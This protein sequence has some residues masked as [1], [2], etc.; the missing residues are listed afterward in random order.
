MQL[1]KKNS[2]IIL[3]VIIFIW[4]FTGIL[5]ELIQMGSIP[6]VIN[7]MI[8][9]FLSLV[10]FEFF[11][12]RKKNLSFKNKLYFFGTGILIS[13]HWVLFF[14][15]INIYNVSLAVTCLSTTAFFTSF[16][17][18]IIKKNK[19]KIH[20]IL[21][22]FFVIIGIIIIF[23]SPENVNLEYR[24]K[25]IILSVFSAMFASI[26]TSL[27]SIFIQKGHSSFQ[28]TKYEMIGG[29]IFT[30]IYWLVKKAKSLFEVTEN[31]NIEKETLELYLIIKNQINTDLIPKG[32]D[33]IY[34]LILSII[35]TSIAY[36]I[37]VE[38]MK[39]IKPFTMNISV[40]M[41]PI[42]AMILAIII[43]KEQEIMS[44][45]FYLGALIIII[46][47]YLNTIFKRN[48]NK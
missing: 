42:Y 6:L 12:F 34:I 18:P 7:R 17:D 48:Q 45:G 23:Y 16:I 19:I 5:G 26:F 25:A 40:N 4:G 21:L 27:N 46:S 28:I 14:E 31:I 41:E 8:I 44:I 38:I 10:L 15:A 33:I 30:F 13:I 24:K 37:S 22:S 3:H 29:A 39:K 47:I 9:A 11:F 20:E 2:L 43:F 32:N 1:S 36:L 35:C